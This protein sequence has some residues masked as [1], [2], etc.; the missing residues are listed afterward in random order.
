MIFTFSLNCGCV[1]YKEEVGILTH[2]YRNPPHQQSVGTKYVIDTVST[3][4]M[5]S[6]WT[7]DYAITKLVGECDGGGGVP[8]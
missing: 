6:R 4:F 3:V 2:L 1:A 8:E 7:I 5:I